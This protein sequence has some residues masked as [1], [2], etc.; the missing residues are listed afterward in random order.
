MFKSRVYLLI[1]CL[2]C[3][4]ERDWRDKQKMVDSLKET[5]DK[6]KRDLDSMRKDVMEKEMLCS[7]LRVGCLLVCELVTVSVVTS[8]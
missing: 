1:I 3:V 6:Q 7:A 8:L 2:F 4:V 5:V